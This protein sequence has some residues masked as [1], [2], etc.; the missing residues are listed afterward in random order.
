M[1][2]L[3]SYVARMSN[4][5]PPTPTTLSHFSPFQLQSPH[6]NNLFI[7]LI[8]DYHQQGKVRISYKYTQISQDLSQSTCNRV[9]LYIAM[10]S[11]RGSLEV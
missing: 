2:D 5:N 4:Q 1:A 7:S 3:S 11:K 9:K 6:P 10:K 8:G